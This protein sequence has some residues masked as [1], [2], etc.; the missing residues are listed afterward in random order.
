[1]DPYLEDPAIWMDF[2]ESFITYC[3]DALNERLPDA[4]ETRIEE[5]INLVQ[6][7]DEEAR[8][9]R[10]DVAISIGS[11]VGRRAARETPETAGVAIA[12]PVIIPLI[13]YDEVR[14]SKIHILRR[15]DRR[16]ITVVELLS[17]TNKTGEGHIQYLSKRN[18]LLTS[19]VHLVEIDLL[20]GGQRLPLAEPLP[21][22]DYYVYVCRGNRRP[23]G[24]IDHW[25]VR[26]PLPAIPIPLAAPDPDLALDLQGL[27]A[28]TYERGRYH[29]SLRYSK[30]PAAPL[31]E[32]DAHWAQSLVPEVNR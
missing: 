16:L 29:R 18:A 2:H 25:S 1:M 14:E 10:A 21:K 11:D 6:M 19:G 9:F 32:G 5:R 31:C 28:T 30:P 23:D 17:P 24:E 12:E 22:G 3:R 8:S 26:Q 15:E 27:F 20:V 7:S 13:I 4:Y